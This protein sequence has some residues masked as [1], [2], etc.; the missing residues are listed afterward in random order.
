MA[1]GVAGPATRRALGLGPGRM[2]KRGGSGSRAG[3][4]RA[5]SVVQR[6]IAAGNRI[7][8]A[9]YKYGGGHGSFRDS[10]YDC[11]DRSPTRCTG[12]AC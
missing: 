1:D 2:L 5:A 12:V 11:S 8:Y 10:G 4:D 3:G 9:P 7:A 6:V